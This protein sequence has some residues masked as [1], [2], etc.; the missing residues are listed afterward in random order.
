MPKAIIFDVD[1]TLVDGHTIPF[2]DIRSQIGKGGDQL[3]PVFLSQAELERDGASIERRRGD[4]LRQTYLP[5]IKAF[6]GVRELF[7]RIKADGV[8]IVLASSAKSEELQTYK[9]LARIE[10]LVDAE[11]SSDDAERSKPHPDI[12]AAAMERLPGVD[13]HDVLVIGDTP[14]D[15]QAAGKAGL[16]TIGVRCGGFPDDSLQRAGCVAIYDGP[17]ELLLEY[18]DSPLSG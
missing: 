7:M 4:I 12:F 11:T 2:D 9:A 14:Y 3:M 13:R 17:G 1:G 6:P 18:D 5:Q 8:R 10:D 15:A 16:R